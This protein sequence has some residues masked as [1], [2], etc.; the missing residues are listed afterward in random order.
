LCS[1][2]KLFTAPRHCNAKV[3]GGNEIFL[4]RKGQSLCHDHVCSYSN[5]GLGN[6]KVAE[7][8]RGRLWAL[9]EQGT[10]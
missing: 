1:F 8:D 2:D 3:E 7:L 9:V 10:F 6:A 5:E 4:A